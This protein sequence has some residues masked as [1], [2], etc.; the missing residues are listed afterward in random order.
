[1]DVTEL[2]EIRINQI[3]ILQTLDVD[4]DLC[5]TINNM[6]HEVH[7]LDSSISYQK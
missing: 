7:M 6:S 3:Q 5:F 4:L 1:M 2:S